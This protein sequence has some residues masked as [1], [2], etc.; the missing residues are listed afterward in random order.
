VYGKTVD[1]KWYEKNKKPVP[2]Q[3]DGLLR[4]QK[5]LGG[6]Q[7]EGKDNVQHS[8]IVVSTNGVDGTAFLKFNLQPWMLTPDAVALAFGE[9]AIAEFITDG[10]GTEGS[11][12][13]T[14]TAVTSYARGRVELAN[15]PSELV[16]EQTAE[17]VKSVLDQIRI[18]VG[19]IYRLQ[20][21]A[22]TGRDETRGLDSLTGIEFA[23][24]IE[25]SNFVKSDGTKDDTAEVKAIYAK[26]KTK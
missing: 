12:A 23:G 7:R 15:T 2:T 13:A 4:I 1:P 24:A 22:G 10:T 11:I 14:R 26:P 9:K 21:W 8:F 19:Q 25:T 20:D 3:H 16:E 6:K 5:Y 18:N 17:Q